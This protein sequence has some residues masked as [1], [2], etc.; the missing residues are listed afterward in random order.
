MNI[1]LTGIWEYWHHA[2]IS[3][4]VS[5][6]TSNGSMLGGV[7]SMKEMRVDKQL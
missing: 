6:Q 3:I 4:Y 5:F 1:L 7:G 2:A